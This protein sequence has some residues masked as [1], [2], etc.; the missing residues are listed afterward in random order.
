MLSTLLDRIWTTT[1]LYALATFVLYTFRYLSPLPI[2]PYALIAAYTVYY[3]QQLTTA[4]SYERKI[5]TLGSRAPVRRTWT[6]SNLGLLFEA[7]YYFSRNRNHEW[8]WGMFDKC[9]SKERGPAW[10]CEAI[11]VAERIIF[12]ADEENI[13]AILATQFQDYGKG[14]AFRKEWKDFLGLSTF[15]AGQ[16]A[17]EGDADG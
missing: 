16:K 7:M 1:A 9:G 12:T 15:H 8:W 2:I 17:R 6:P 3:A 10:T 14:P 5:D 11:T 13:K 4:V